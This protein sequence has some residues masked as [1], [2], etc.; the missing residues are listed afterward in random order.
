MTLEWIINTLKQKDVNS[1]STV[2]KALE[3]I[4]S[5]GLMELRRSINEEINKKVLEEYNLE[6]I[7]KS[8]R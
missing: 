7:K 5:R 6:D 1:N 8:V 4:D 3:N 2:I